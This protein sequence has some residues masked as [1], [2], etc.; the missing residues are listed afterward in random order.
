MLAQRVKLSIPVV[1]AIEKDPYWGLKVVTLIRYCTALG[2]SAGPYVEALQTIWKRR[3]KK[4]RRMNM[5]S[6]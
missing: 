6:S 2:F 4:P 1:R 5:D 3:E